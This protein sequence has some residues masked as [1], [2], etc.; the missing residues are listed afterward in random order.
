MPTPRSTY[1]NV[2]PPRQPSWMFQIF[3]I[4]ASI[5]AQDA[6][7]PV[8]PASSKPSRGV[9][10]GTY[11]QARPAP[12]HEGSVLLGGVDAREVCFAVRAQDGVS[13]LQDA[14][15]LKTLGALKR[16]GRKC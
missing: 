13:V 1:E 15:L 4:G 2:N 11:L 7:K 16:R 12:L 10:K 9:I 14:Q 3:A 8:F 6:Q 5:R